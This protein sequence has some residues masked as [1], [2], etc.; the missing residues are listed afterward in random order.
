M[1]LIGKSPAALRDLTRAL[2]E[3]VAPAASLTPAQQAA[4]GMSLAQFVQAAWPIIE[5]ATP[6]VWSWTMEAVCAH[7][8]ALLEGRLSKR[9]LVVNIPPG[10]AK[11]TIVS[12]C[13]PAWRWILK[14]AWRSI[15]ASGNPAV[16]TR[17]SM[18][19]RAILESTWYRRTFGIS[20][21]LADDANLKT[22][23]EN[24]AKGFRVALS[25]GS[26]V[27]GD[28]ADSLFIDDPLDAA[29][30]YSS[31]ARANVHSWFD[32]AFANRLNDMRTGTRVLIAQRLHPE[33][34]AGHVLST[35]ADAWETLVIP[36]EFEQSRRYTTS[37]GWT[38]PR[39]ADGE[40]AFPERFPQ[41]V[42]DSERMRLGDSGYA[43]QH[44][45]RPFSAEGEVFKRGGLQLW[46][47]AQPLP[48]FSTV[49]VSLDTAFKT[50]E[51]S[52]YS[53]GFAIGQFDK[54]YMLL[55]RVRGRFAYPA[56]KQIMTEWA[57]R[58]KPSAVL[59]EDAASGQSLIQDLQFGTSLPVV[60]VRPDGDKLM[61]AHTIVPLWESNRIFVA[62]G[63]V[64]IPEFL[65]ELHAFPKSPHD[66]QVD[67]FVQG[68]RWL[69]RPAGLG[70]LIFAQQELDAMNALK[71]GASTQQVT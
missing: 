5:P 9:N 33:D 30:A 40:L 21:K 44:Q 47:E 24:T 23:Y 43:G 13:T 37:L 67:A 29:D 16:S 17:D 35:E 26:R 41:S 68:V 42:L 12:V 45:Q 66:D 2:L 7:V 55:D 48:Q 11:S 50:K 28:R 58:W 18:K 60:A 49:V 8:Q 36:Q 38:D 61:R 59:V 3:A 71:R 19:C 22:R 6:L 64:W 34:L 4:R 51:E 53:V 10:F 52:D 1:N 27:T 14:P 57:T 25:S 54:G 46:P 56:L 70:F 63:T 20:W 65:E 69:V 62:A 31:A 32:S 39:T 15:F